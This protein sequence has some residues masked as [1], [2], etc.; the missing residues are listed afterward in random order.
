[1][2]YVNFVYYVHDI[3]KDYQPIANEY[4]IYKF[5]WCPLY[6]TDGLMHSLSKP[7]FVNCSICRLQ[8]PRGLRRGSTVVRLLG[9]RVRIPPEHGCLSVSVVYRQVVFS[10]TGR[11]LVQRSSTECDVSECDRRASQSRPRLTRAVER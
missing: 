7:F 3:S 8:W 2:R 11:T 4:K 1:M 10:A 6:S 9:L 5:M